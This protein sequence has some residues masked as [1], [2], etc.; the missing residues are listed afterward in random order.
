MSTLEFVSTSAGGIAD[1]DAPLVTAP[2]L[3]AA[4]G[5]HPALT[6]PL[7]GDRTPEA[8][9]I[10]RR[11]AETAHFFGTELPPVT[12]LHDTL[13]SFRDEVTAR[14]GQVD[15]VARIMVVEVDGR[16]RFVVSGAVI[17]PARPEPVVLSV[18]ATPAAGPA[19]HWREMAARTS[20]HAEADLAERRLRAGGYA[21]EVYTDGELVHRPRLGALIIDTVGIGADR[22]DLLRAAGLLDGVRYSDEPVPISGAARAWWVSPRFE[23]HPVSAIGARRFEVAPV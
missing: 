9:L 13:Q 16:A 6:A 19:P 10:W 8:G 2:A 18:T 14:H 4:L 17:D 21:D 23:T 12:A 22:L 7:A 20:S 5:T 11:L 1:G 3:V 15:L